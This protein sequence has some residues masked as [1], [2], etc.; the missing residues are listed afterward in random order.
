[1]AGE[2]DGYV[3]PALKDRSRP[4]ENYCASRIDIRAKSDIT[5]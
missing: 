5:V 1:M 2:K 4:E 3:P